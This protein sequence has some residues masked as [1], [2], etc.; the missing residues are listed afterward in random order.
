MLV[1]E[2]G[3]A[4]VG[5]VDQWHGGEDAANQLCISRSMKETLGPSPL[6]KRRMCYFIFPQRQLSHSNCFALKS[7]VVRTSL[8]CLL[9]S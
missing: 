9:A 7:L 6:T 5:T 3:G 8:H 2:L 1:W 4:V